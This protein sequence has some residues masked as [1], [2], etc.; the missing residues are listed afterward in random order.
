M[1][2]KDIETKYGKVL[3]GIEKQIEERRSEG[4]LSPELENL[5][6]DQAKGAAELKTLILEDMKN[7]PDPAQLHRSAGKL[8]LEIS[9]MDECPDDLREKAEEGA[10]LAF[11]KAGEKLVGSSKKLEKNEKAE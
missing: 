8:L 6:L 2:K 10:W 3:D 11:R 9:K 5:M 7:G 4:T 1:R